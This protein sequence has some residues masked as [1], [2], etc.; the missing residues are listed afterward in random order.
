MFG[1]YMTSKQHEQTNNQEK[2]KEYVAFSTVTPEIR[3]MWHKLEALEHAQAKDTST[4]REFLD[5]AVSDRKNHC[6][7]GL[8]TRFV[9]TD[10]PFAFSDST[11]IFRDA[12]F[13]SKW[14]EVYVVS[15]LLINAHEAH[16]QIVDAYVEVEDITCVPTGKEYITSMA[17]PKNKQAQDLF[18]FEQ[19]HPTRIYPSKELA[20]WMTEKLDQWGYSPTE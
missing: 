9:F 10:C 14:I 17:G 6:F 11:A 2:T 4:L 1:D 7:D 19:M 18:R 16:K 15:G 20:A 13:A 12:V 5:K 8:I 3:D